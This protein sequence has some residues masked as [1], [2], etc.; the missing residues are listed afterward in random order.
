MSMQSGEMLWTSIKDVPYGSSTA[1]LQNKHDNK[2]IRSE[3]WWQNRDVSVKRD[4]EISES[5]YAGGEMSRAGQVQ[6]QITQPNR[7][8]DT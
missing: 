7:S 6:N 8:A 3:R 5:N 4:T 2:Y 1:Y